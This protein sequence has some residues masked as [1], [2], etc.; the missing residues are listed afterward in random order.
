MRSLPLTAL[1]LAA[2][3]TA[4]PEPNVTAERSLPPTPTPARCPIFRCSS[5]FTCGI[6]CC[7]WGGRKCPQGWICYRNSDQFRCC[8]KNHCPKWIWGDR[9]TAD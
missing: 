4:N 9:E 6:A 5:P 8:K 1:I 2:L 7:P 3:A